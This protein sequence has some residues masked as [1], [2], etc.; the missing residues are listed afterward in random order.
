MTGHRTWGNILSDFNVLLGIDA[1]AD[2]STGDGSGADYYILMGVFAMTQI[3]VPAAIVTSGQQIVDIPVV[4]VFPDNADYFEVGFFS[5]LLGAGRVH[6]SLLAL[7]P[8]LQVPRDFAPDPRAAAQWMQPSPLHVAS[9]VGSPGALTIA[10][11]GTVTAGNYAG[12]LLLETNDPLVPAVTIPVTYDYSTPIAIQDLAAVQEGPDVVVRWV[13]ADPRDVAS[14]RVYRADDGDAFAIVSAD[15]EPASGAHTFRDRDVPP[16]RHVYRVG[17]V[18]GRGEVT[19]HGWTEI[20]VVRAVPG[21]HLPGSGGAES[22]QSIDHTALRS[23]PREPGDAGRVRCARPPGTDLVASPAARSRLPP[24]RLG[25]PRR[26]R[27]PG[28]ER[29]LPRAFRSRGPGAGAT[30]DVD[31]IALQAGGGSALN[32][33]SGSVARGRAGPRVPEYKKGRWAVFAPRA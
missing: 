24:S 12:K 3:G 10:F 33:S 15:L 19:L 20:D 5:H 9:P 13:A 32:C 23:G 22:V 21:S 31:Q 11:P 14:L 28:R 25:R 18:D 30:A 6:L 27:P 29:H 4:Q 8:N 1:D 2:R 16:G 7:D 17:E 26:G